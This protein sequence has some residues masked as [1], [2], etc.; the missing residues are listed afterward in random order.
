MYK[1]MFVNQCLSINVSL[2]VISEVVAYIMQQQYV[3]R[4]IFKP[5]LLFCVLISDLKMT[6]VQIKRVSKNKN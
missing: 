6:V 2:E 4:I 5:D 3:H 1:D